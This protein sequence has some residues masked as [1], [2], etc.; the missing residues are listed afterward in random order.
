MA[1]LIRLATGED[2]AAIAAVYRPYVEGSRISFEEK[3]PDGAEMSRRIAGD[4]R[5]LH[6]WLVAEEDQRLLGFANGTP[7]RVRPAYRWAVETGIYLDRNA[8]GRGLGKILLSEL[9]ALLERQ[10]YVTAVAGIALPNEASVAL[11]ERLG[12]VHTGT[13]QRAGFKLG[14][15]IDVGHWQRDLAPHTDAPAEPRPFAPLFNP[16]G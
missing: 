7:F 9:V 2:A 15:W 1:G 12:F 6:P 14:E 4:G 13:Y 8:T 11:H 16:G 10:G 3:A 5:G